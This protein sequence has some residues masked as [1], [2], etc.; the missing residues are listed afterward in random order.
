VKR[1]IYESSIDLFD[2]SKFQLWQGCY[3]FGMSAV[4]G[5]SQAAIRLKPSTLPQMASRISRAS[6]GPTPEETLT[7]LRETAGPRPDY[8]LQGNGTPSQP[9]RRVVDPA[10][11]KIPY[12]PWAAAKTKGNSG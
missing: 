6:G 12:Q 2:A 7:T 11:G 10:D 3:V 5:Q 4:F 1:G 8:V 9:T